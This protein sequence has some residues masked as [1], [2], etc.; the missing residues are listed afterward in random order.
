[1]TRAFENMTVL[2]S[3]GATGIGRA[4]ALAFARQGAQVVI[5]NR[6]VQAGEAVVREILAAHPGSKPRFLATDV[7]QE[8]QVRAL[9]DHAVKTTGRL[10]AAF[11][12]AGVE[13]QMAPLTEQTE[14]NFHHVMSINVKGLWLCMK[15]EIQAM[16]ALGHGGAIVNNA[17]IAGVIGMAGAGIYV[18]SKHAVIGL[19]K[20]AAL[21]QAK[22]GIRVNA[23]SPAAIDTPM[24]D[25]F[26]NT[27]QAREYLKSLHPV[28]RIGQPE[29]IA[30]GVTWLCSREA[31]FVT[32]HNLVIDGGF[33]IQ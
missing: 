5:G 29:E 4:A 12:N 10:D 2:I 11:N 27:D 33:T 28:G 9:V 26:A 13:G 7:S 15:H 20:S 14:Q 3:G 19:T 31:S 17:S 24:Y 18:A 30:G 25:R 16:L 23:V 32:G 6:N 1:M 8:A 22:A 21:E